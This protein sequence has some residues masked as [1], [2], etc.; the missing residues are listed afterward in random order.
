RDIEGSHKWLWERYLEDLP[1]K[2]SAA[3]VIPQELNRGHGNLAADLAFAWRMTGQDSL[4][5]QSRDYLLGLCN[6]EVWDP[7][8]ELVQGHM[9]MG[10]ALAYDWLYSGLTRSERSLV[11]ARLGEEAQRQYSLIADRR[12]WYRSQY[13][14]NHAHVHYGGLAYAAVALYG[15]DARAQQWLGACVD[16]FGKVLELSLGDGTS[17]EGLSYGNYALEYV[18]R[19]TELARTVLGLDCYDNPW[20][21]NYPRYLI[22]SL[23]PVMVENEWAM[24]FGDNPRHGNSH[25]PEPQL[26]LIASRCGEKDAQWLGKKLIGLR[27]SGLASASW[28]AILW[29]DPEVGE[30]GPPGFPTLG[31]F[32]DLDQVMLRSAWEDTSAVML[33]IKC[34]PFMGRARSRDAKYDLGCAHGHPDAGS[35]QLYAHGRFL[36]V[37]PMYTY[38]KS[39]ANHNTLLVKGRGQLGEDEQWFAAAEALYYG[40]YPVVLEAR[41]TAELDY[42][43]ADLAAAYHPALGLKKALRHFVFIKPD[44]LLVADEL[45][46]DEEGVLFSYPADTL[47]LGGALKYESGYVS[48]TRGQAEVPFKGPPGT[49]DIAVSYLDNAPR[50]GRYA[51]TVDGDTAHVWRD[52]VEATDTHLEVARDIQLADTSRIAFCA[53][54]MGEGAKLVKIMVSGSEVKA[55]RDVQWLLHCDPETEFTRSFTRIEAAY[56]P[57]CLDIYPL[58]PPQRNHQWGVHQVKNGSRMKQTQRLVIKPVFTD[59]TTTILT[60]LHARKGGSPPLDWLRGGLYRNVATVNWVRAGKAATLTFDLEKREIGIK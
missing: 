44:I 42:V 5:E 24:T 40:H 50:T 19:Y 52:T 59:S 11:A 16:F 32:A 36:A 29:Y 2:L 39:T 48:G 47:R 55:E 1:S 51:I 21:R 30:A 54:P 33:G 57:V 35:F 3:G 15:E 27:S 17:I 45:T 4:F 43:L 25:G 26:F 31:H 34:G 41:S 22:H 18:L 53:D 7:D 28:W 23:L 13:L 14:Q 20:V 56:G 9:L 38:F 49:Y 60:L 10:V 8:Y 12:A 58:A 37:D 6:K 46:L